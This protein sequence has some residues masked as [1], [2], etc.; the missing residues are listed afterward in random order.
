MSFSFQNIFDK[1]NDFSFSAIRKSF[2]DGINNTIYEQRFRFS[3]FIP[4]LFASGIIFY[5]SLDNEPKIA[6]YVFA[7]LT[8]AAAYIFLRMPWNFS[9]ST[10]I[11]FQKLRIFCLILIFPIAGFLASYL[12]AEWVNIDMLD[13]KVSYVNLLGTINYSEKSYNGTR[14]ILE[15]V[16]C[17]SKKYKK[18]FESKKIGKISLIWRGNKSK[19]FNQDFS[20]GSFLSVKAI[21]EPIYP[22]KFKRAYDF[23]MQSYFNGISARGYI[24][25]QPTVYQN[26]VNWFY[27]IKESFRFYINKKIQ[28]VINGKEGGIAQAL[29]TGNKSVIDKTIRKSFSDSGMAHLLAISGLHIGIIGG[30]FFVL[31]RL[32]FCLFPIVALRFDAKKISAVLSLLFVF[33]YLKI[34][35]ESVPAIRAF[36]MHAIIVI[37]IICNRTAFSMRSVAIAAIGIMIFQPEAILFPSFQMSFSAVIAL[38]AFYEKSWRYPRYLVAVLTLLSTSAI[39][40]LATS[41]FTV[42]TFNRFTIAAIFS[43]LLAVPLTSFFIMPLSIISVFFMF[44]SR[45]EIPL[46]FLEF[47]IKQLVKLSDFWAQQKYLV[48]QIPTPN[49]Q[50][51][52]FIVL[53]LLLCA[54]FVSKVRYI[55]TGIAI[56]GTVMLFFHEQPLA[57][58][59]DYGKLVGIKTENGICFNSLVKLRSSSDEIAKTFGNENKKK[60]GSRDCKDICKT[61][62]KFYKIFR[63]N[64][65]IGFEVGKFESEEIYEK[66]G[67]VT[68][69][70]YKR[71][72]RKWS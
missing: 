67:V 28:S 69:R 66:C 68:Y 29:I 24:I 34:S 2:C 22:K 70:E 21:L 65:D 47:G 64:N 36:I 30:F 57:I 45:E 39:A 49:S 5:F 71:Q 10:E 52:L 48:F 40:S 50:I 46:L 27:K 17:L 55:G 15:D 26:N 20:P 33:L 72:N 60:L 14:I 19:N 4:V 41:L 61:S 44:F 62:N 56:V 58:A 53:G 9:T 6:P 37:A 32:L 43:N 63:E 11:L 35:G 16:K 59:I 7:F 51:L 18:L 23:R 1:T 38:V 3:H 12:R 54:L 31:F 25:A 13:K 42:Y 8:L